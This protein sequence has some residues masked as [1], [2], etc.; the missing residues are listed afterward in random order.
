VLTHLELLKQLDVGPHQ[1]C[2]VDEGWVLEHH[3]EGVVVM[4]MRRSKAE[5]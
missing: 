3:V 2:E 4:E 1:C 5:L